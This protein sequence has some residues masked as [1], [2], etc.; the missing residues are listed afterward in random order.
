MSGRLRSTKRV[1]RAMMP[2]R[3]RRTL[4]AFGVVVALTLGLVA[5]SAF[6]YFATHGSGTGSA[7]LGTL[8]VAVST[9]YSAAVGGYQGP[10]TSASVGCTS[11]TLSTVGP[12]GS[13]FDTSPIPVTITN[14]GSV[15]VT[16]MQVAVSDMNNNTT[17]EG[18]LGLCLYKSG[19]AQLNG[20]LTLLEGTPAL[21]PGSLAVGGSDTYSVD[22]YAGQSSSQCG[23]PAIPSLTPG[24]EGGWVTTTITVTFNA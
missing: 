24:A 17:M 4:V 21:L 10:C 11:I 1:L 16:E 15:P 18:E 5:S 23:G 2:W 9:P 19:A 12:V 20:L 13:S 7:S 6:G 8:D 22:F 3:W 14:T